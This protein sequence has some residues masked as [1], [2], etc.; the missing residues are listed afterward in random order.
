MEGIDLSLTTVT[1][2]EAVTLIINS[3]NSTTVERN[4]HHLYDYGVACHIEVNRANNR[5]ACNTFRG[6]GNKFIFVDDGIL[7]L[8]YHARSNVVDGPIIKISHNKYR[9]TPNFSKYF[10][11]V[12]CYTPAFLNANSNW[13]MANIEY[14]FENKTPLLSLWQK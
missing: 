3:I 2:K 13:S 7:I 4:S 12:M 6:R 11:K 14:I 9:M 5:I 8:Y 1:L 10:E